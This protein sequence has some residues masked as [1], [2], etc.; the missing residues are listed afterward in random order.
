MK[1]FFSIILSI[2][3]VFSLTL[4]SCERNADVDLPDVDSKLALSC[5]I[6]PQDTVIR[7]YVTRS[8]PVF[9]LGSAN[10]QHQAVNN[11]TV[12]LYDAS[13]SVQLTFNPLLEQYEI[14]AA[15]FPI[16]AGQTY[17]ITVALSGYPTLE[18]STRVPLSVPADFSATADLIIDSTSFPGFPLIEADIDHQFTDP[19]GDNNYYLINA[20]LNLNDTLNGIVRNYELARSIVSDHNADGEVI[21]GSLRTGI[22]AQG[23]LNSLTIWL[24]SGTYDYYEF[25]RTILN[26]NNGGDPFSEPTLVYSNVTNGFGIFAGCNS[27]NVVIPL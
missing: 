2:A 21:R 20:V 6:S 12:M 8:I 27:T 15:S 14:P 5:F 16:V 18:A 3:A 22:N 1:Q 19:A 26:G 9:E 23:S 24:T 13:G 25:H 10:T 4:T 7:A 11:A 17:R